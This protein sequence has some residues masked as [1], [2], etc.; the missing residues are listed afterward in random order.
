MMKKFE[1]AAP[2]RMGGMHFWGGD[3]NSMPD[4]RTEKMSMQFDENGSLLAL[5]AHDYFL[6]APLFPARQKP[7][8]ICLRF[9]P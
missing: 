7:V 9:H 1:Q 3:I 6:S 8:A 2:G 4:S 5:P